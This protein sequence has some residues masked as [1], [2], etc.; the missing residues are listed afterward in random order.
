MS[1]NL[2][3]IEKQ[4]LASDANSAIERLKE[5]DKNSVSIEN[6][7]KRNTKAIVVKAVDSQTDYEK[8]YYKRDFH[9]NAS[10]EIVEN[11]TNKTTSQIIDEFVCYVVATKKTE[12]MTNDL[13]LAFQTHGSSYGDIIRRAM[14]QLASKKVNAI[15]I[16]NIKRKDS[17]KNLY[18]YIVNT[19]SD[20]FKDFFIDSEVAK[21][22]AKTTI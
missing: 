1:K 20:L 6:K 8:R 2:S 7:S 11:C 15:K 17:N 12:F 18:K 9:N 14:R 5:L 16:R 21:T 22:E 4:K 19:K 10:L 13:I 3:E